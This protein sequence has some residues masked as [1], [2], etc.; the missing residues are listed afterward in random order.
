MI[1]HQIRSCL[2]DRATI[3]YTRPLW[4]SLGLKAFF[5]SSFKFWQ[6]PCRLD[7]WRTITRTG[8][9]YYIWIQRS[10]WLCFLLD[11]TPFVVSLFQDLGFPRCF[12][13]QYLFLPVWHLSMPPSPWGSRTKWQTENFLTVIRQLGVFNSIDGLA[14][15]CCLAYSSPLMSGASIKAWPWSD[16]IS[17]SISA[18]LSRG[19]IDFAWALIC[20]S[21]K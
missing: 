8:A 19:H 3:L 6:P 5:H 14:L 2:Q 1:N 12:L 4:L 16:S 15:P 20:V 11:Q 17:S 13:I 7:G 18:I 10:A 9:F 21:P